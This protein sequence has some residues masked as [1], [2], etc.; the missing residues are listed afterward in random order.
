MTTGLVTGQQFDI[1]SI[2]NL[3]MMMM[4]MVMM[5][6]MMSKATAAV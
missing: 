4:V 1:S 2:M 6:K 5:M 3:M